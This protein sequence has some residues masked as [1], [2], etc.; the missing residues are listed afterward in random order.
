[1]DGLIADSPSRQKELAAGVRRVDR[2]HP[3]KALQIVVLAAPVIFLVIV[4]WTHRGVF[5]DGYIYLHIVQN[6]LAGNGPVFNSGQRVEVF[7]GPLWTGILALAAF[8]T[9]FSLEWIAVVLGISMTIGGMVLALA[10][11]VGLSRAVEP[12]AF[13]LPI[14]AVVFVATYPVWTLASM[15]LETGLTFLWLG[16]CLFLLVRW[17][18]SAQLCRL[19]MV[20]LGLGTLVRPELF[21]D[22]VVFIVAVAIDLTMS[23]RCRLIAWAAAVPIAYEVFRMGYY[24]ELVANTA[25]AKEGTL[26]RPGHGWDYLIDFVGPYWLVIPLLA[27]VVGAYIP[28]CSSIRGTSRRALLA[29]PIA[30]L[31]NVF[32]VV[33]IG[34]DYIHARLLI[35]AFF[36]ICAPVAVVPAGRKYFVSLVVLPWAVIAAWSLRPPTPDTILNANASIVFPT[37]DGNVTPA[38]VGWAPGSPN[39][40]WFH[41]AAIYA[42]FGIFFPS[43]TKLID[44]PANGMVRLPT[45]AASAVGAE[46]YTLGT[47][48]DILDMLG[49]ADPL[50]AHFQLSR[51]GTTGH[52]KPM[53]TPWVAAILTRPGSSIKPF[54]V[55]QKAADPRI[56]PLIPQ[57]TGTA[58]QDQTAWARAALQCPTIHHIEYGG[59]GP[60]T[61]GGFISNIAHAFDNSRVRIQPDPEK[62][63]HQFCGPG[64]P[65]GF[66]E[67]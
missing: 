34:G 60:L 58:L 17:S 10:G 35:P 23:Q 31:L 6:I 67:T 52:E 56:V 61:F 45:V 62:A 47:G 63:Y 65:R 2:K 46:S 3:S 51:R 25:I 29:L 9:P 22:S 36:A 24:G 43:Q 30:G 54:D 18:S 27:L 53:P 11:S 13:L 39:L 32:Y 4:A 19:A 64:L 21:I 14:G 8:I 66:A 37:G 42:Y 44:L 55:L 12:R 20:L 50:D 15:G 57:T 59:D 48:V 7:T 28:I 5:E 26:P 16:L 40:A 41:G 49:L 1:M 38:S 33:L